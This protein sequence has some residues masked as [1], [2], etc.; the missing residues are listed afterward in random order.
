MVSMPKTNRCIV[1]DEED[2][3]F[4]MLKEGK[5]KVFFGLSALVSSCLRLLAFSLKA[6]SK[7]PGPP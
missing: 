5:E 6:S 2:G 4:G 7:V 1:T 3:G